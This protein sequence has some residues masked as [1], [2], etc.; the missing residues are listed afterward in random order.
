MNYY[1]PHTLL[2]TT[3]LSTFSHNV[4]LR[5]TIIAQRIGAKLELVHVLD[6]K[7]LNELQRLV[8]KNSKAVKEHI[9]SQTRDL[10]LQLANDV[11]EPLGENA[12]CHL[13]EGEVIEG[14]TTQVGALNANLLIVGA[15]GSSFIHQRLL[16]TTTE[17][18]LRMT[19]CPVLTVK[20]PPK[21]VYQRV[22]VPIDFSP[23]S[24]A[25][26]RMALVIAP[27]AELILLHAYK[28]PF[29]EQMNIAGES[30]DTIQGYRDKV[31]QESEARLHQTAMEAGIATGNWR[32]I[33]ILG[34]AVQRILEL[35]EKQGSDLVVLGKHGHGVVN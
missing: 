21:E 15:Q 33:V 28:V 4:V 5:A 11:G 10:L 24:L 31:F 20:R 16:G 12:I 1:S 19:Q 32:P 22:L 7:E 14:I 25:A 9:R 30:K 17:R 2:A 34:D 8:G 23:W 27:Q 29:E 26:I 13:V 3:D 6:K 35:E 18:L